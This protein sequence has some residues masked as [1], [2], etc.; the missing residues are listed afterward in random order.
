MEQDAQAPPG[1][2]QPSRT[3]EFKAGQD[4]ERL[5]R[6]L[7]RKIP[8]SSRAH[9]QHLIRKGLVSVEDR[10]GKQSD[11]LKAGARVLVQWELPEAP[12]LR[13]E[14]RDVKL[15]YSDEDLVVVDKPAGVV[16]HPAP[17]AKSGTLVNA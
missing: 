11:R 7:Q 1:S 16:V 9:L 8:E 5:D 14:S 12:S 3:L 17:G 13:P 6:F 15:L 10:R 2:L 4:E